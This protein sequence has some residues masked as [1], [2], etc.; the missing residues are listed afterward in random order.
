MAKIIISGG[1][2]GG[3]IFPAIA[4]ADA[5]MQLDAQTEILFVGAEGKMEMERVPKAGYKIIGLPIVGFQRKAIFKNLLF[6]LK[7]LKSLLKSRKI[8]T[9]FKPDVVV[10]V[11]GYASAPVLSAAQFNRIPTI[12]QEQNSYAGVTNKILSQKS[13]KICVAY[14]DMAKYFPAEKIIWTGNPVRKDILNLHHKRK[15]A[16]VH[17]GLHDDWQTIL[18]TGGS[19]GAFVLNESVAQSIDFLKK[20]NNIQIIWQCGKSYFDKYKNS[21][22]AQLQNVKLLSFLEHI[23]WAYAAAD[24]VICRAGALTISELCLAGKAAVLIPSPHVAEDHQT[25][26][27]MSLINCEAALFLKDSVATAEALKMAVAILSDTDL[28][29]RLEQNI[30]KLAKPDAAEDIAKEIFKQIKK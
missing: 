12:I 16:N 20:Q 2:T 19:L 4:I 15:E 17:F 8:V 21:A 29:H 28:K 11:G 1:G 5:L 7:L 22:V 3:H 26:N 27:A 23:D 24:V 13:Q 14:P 10:G 30:L 18:V 25:K 9:D 6:P